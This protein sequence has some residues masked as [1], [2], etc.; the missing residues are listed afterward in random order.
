MVYYPGSSLLETNPSRPFQRFICPPGH[1]ITAMVNSFCDE[2]VD[3][4]LML[5]IQPWSVDDA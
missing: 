3:V 1:N 2:P 5:F 4:R